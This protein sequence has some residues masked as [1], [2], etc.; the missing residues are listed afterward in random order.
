[1]LW[2]VYGIVQTKHGSKINVRT[3]RYLR[4]RVDTE[5]VCSLEPFLGD[6][7]DDPR[8]MRETE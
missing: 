3:S 5:T 2:N 7:L 4:R 6:S 8:R 1:M